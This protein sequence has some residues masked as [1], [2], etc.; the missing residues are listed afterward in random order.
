[1]RLGSGAN[2]DFTLRFTRRIVDEHLHDKAVELGLRQRIGAFML[3][4]ILRSQRHEWRSEFQRLAIN[5]D[6]LFLHDF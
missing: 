2:D 3:D 5:R 4:R 1:M 6:L